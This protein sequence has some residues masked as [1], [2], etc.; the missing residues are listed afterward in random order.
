M[1]KNK[2]SNHYECDQPERE[3]AYSTLSPFSY[4]RQ[5]GLQPSPYNQQIMPQQYYVPSIMSS[6]Q[7]MAPFTHSPAH[8]V[9]ASQ[10][11]DPPTSS[12]GN[13]QNGAQWK[14]KSMD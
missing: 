6:M 10:F 1:A 5:P 13:A 11:S 8:A 2:D 3:D 9:P 4:A 14:K 12:Q 7:M